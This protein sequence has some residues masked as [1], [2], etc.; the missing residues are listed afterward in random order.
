MIDIEQ[1]TFI[2]KLNRQYGKRKA[3]RAAYPLKGVNNSN[4]F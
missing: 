1:C 4:K 3:S 2:I